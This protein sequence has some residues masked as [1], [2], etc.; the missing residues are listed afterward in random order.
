MKI[1]RDLLIKR[2]NPP[3]T[4]DNSDLSKI[5]ST[6]S[7]NKQ[8]VAKALA[9]PVNDASIE[10]LRAELFN[11]IKKLVHDINLNKK[12]IKKWKYGAKKFNKLWESL[13]SG[14]KKLLSPKDKESLKALCLGEKPCAIFFNLIPFYNK[15]I[16]EKNGCLIKSD[17]TSD[18]SFVYDKKL[19][20]AIVKQHEDIF[21]GK[22][23]IKN[24]IHDLYTQTLNRSL[25]PDA[26]LKLG[27]ILG[28]PKEAC[29]EFNQLSPL[30]RS[31]LSDLDELGFAELWYGTTEETT[32]QRISQMDIEQKNQLKIA[33]QKCKKSF[34]D[35]LLKSQNSI[36][37]FLIPA[38]IWAQ[39]GDFGKE[40]QQ[41]LTRL[42][43]AFKIAGFPESFEITPLA[44]KRLEDSLEDYRLHE[45][46]IK[47][48]N[49]L[50]ESHLK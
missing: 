23:T 25:T 34:Q 7:L 9:Q 45:E 31:S 44:L 28:Y 27:L 5:S 32:V 16:F 50:E 3:P 21:K 15:K 29:I 22:T 4:L 46:K 24:L 49:S 41:K 20:K 39:K 17:G 40:A 36:S 38:Y 35:N 19:V 42:T 13:P 26:H 6:F 2:N 37:L 18:Q 1:L 8:L 10:L 47:F 30:S 12:D 43:S 14:F 48:L 11:S 33:V